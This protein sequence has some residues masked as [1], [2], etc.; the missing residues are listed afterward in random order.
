M[1]QWRQNGARTRTRDEPARHPILFSAVRW[2]W[3]E[4]AIEDWTPAS[5]RV[6][7][8]LTS[9]Y[10]RCVRVWPRLNSGRWSP[11]VVAILLPLAAISSSRVQGRYLLVN[12]AGPAA[13]PFECRSSP[14]LGFSWSW[15]RWRLHSPHN[16]YSVLNRKGEMEMEN[17][18][19][20]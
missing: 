7:Q 13:A 16:Y 20:N 5:T 1:K 18:D 17:G 9:W 15:R 8:I 11:P 19:S 6:V 10:L 12:S 3:E 14:G 2:L 4:E